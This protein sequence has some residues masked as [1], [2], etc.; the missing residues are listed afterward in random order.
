MDKIGETI[1]R[2]RTMSRRLASAG[3]VLTVCLSTAFLSSQTK[4]QPTAGKVGP[5]KPPTTDAAKIKSALSAAPAALAKD[6]TVVDIN[7]QTMQMKVLKKGTNG[8][9]CM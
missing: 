9:T 4:T 5:V 1:S 6:A 8:W 2:R 3:F 7:M